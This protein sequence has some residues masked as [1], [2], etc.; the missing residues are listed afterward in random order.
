MAAREMRECPNGR[1]RS[2]LYGRA[3][4]NTSATGFAWNL[5]NHLPS[6]LV[7]RYTRSGVII[8]KPS[9][10][11][12]SH[13]VTVKNADTARR[14]ESHNAADSSAARGITKTSGSPSPP[15]VTVKNEHECIADDVNDCGNSDSR[16]LSNTISDTP[17]SCSSGVT[18]PSKF[19]RST[20]ASTP[21]AIHPKVGSNDRN[22]GGIEIPKS[23]N[24]C[25]PS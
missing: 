21:L 5:P 11:P 13:D 18:N 2:G 19:V 3:T 10:T 8:S 25:L 12:C 4:A 1:D 22:C 15:D 7:N 9:G 6:T 14:R 16:L 20:R 23:R 24:S 17:K